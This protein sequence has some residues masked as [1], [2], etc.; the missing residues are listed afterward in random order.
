MS[1]DIVTLNVSITNPAAP[2][3]LLRTGAFISQG[4]TILAQ[5]TYSLLTQSSDLT[6]ILAGSKAIT[7]LA[8]ASSV[9]TVTTTSPHG[10]T[11]GD[12]LELTISGAVPTGYNGTFECTVTGASTLTYALA[13]N[14]GAMT[15]SGVLT[16]T[17]VA[18]LTAMNTTF[19]AQGS[20]ASVYVLELGEGSPEQG[21]TALASFITTNPGIFFSYLVPREWADES[22]FKTMVANYTSPTA[23]V[24]FFVTCSM[25]NWS[26]WS[27]RAT[28]SSVFAMIEAPDIPDTEYS[29]AAVFYVTLNYNPSSSNLV[30][31]LCFSFLY[32]VTAYPTFGNS[33]LL[34]SLKTGNINYVS[35]AAEG[36]LSNLMLVWG[37][38][39]DGNP[40][41][42]W[43]TVAWAIINI[44]L[45]LS[46]EI[47]NGSNSS[48]NPLF[49][50][51]LGINRLQNRAKKTLTNGASYG[52]ILGS[53]IST[54][55]SQDDF[56]ANF[57]EGDYVGKYVVN[58]VPFSSYSALN[59]SDYEDGKYS[60]LSAV[61]TPLRGF[62]SIIFNL[63][64]TNFVG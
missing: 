52:L 9:V 48:T 29:L 4:G 6:A 7:T 58:A 13:T 17:D 55:L 59:P 18:T 44:N 51:Q 56:I 1:T 35:T 43:Y 30:S 50:D 23:L 28:L 42:Y 5:G 57:N 61:I 26:D 38:M 31:P 37:H 14:P 34:S 20:N 10:F 27:A 49:Y 39:L 53:L 33:S 62:E 22:T 47:I 25:S 15:T 45:D 41:N 64:V 24:K 12:V 40:F 60:G 46:N 19:W 21:V 32:G 8:W 2:S 16:D 54:T 11:T 3:K 63:N 36:G